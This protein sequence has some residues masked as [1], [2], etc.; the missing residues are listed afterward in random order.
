MIGVNTMQTIKPFS[1][2]HD[3]T[4]SDYHQKSVRFSPVVAVRLCDSSHILLPAPDYVARERA[5]DQTFAPK[6][7]V[8]YFFLSAVHAC[9]VV[10]D[11]KARLGWFFFT[12]HATLFVKFGK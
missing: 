5:S 9:I 8:K 3:C 2:Q 7:N 11:F 10:S 6:R 1:P 12:L 4:V